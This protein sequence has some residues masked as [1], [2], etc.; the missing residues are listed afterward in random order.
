MF[1]VLIEGTAIKLVLFGLDGPSWPKAFL[2]AL[3]LNSVSGYVGIRAGISFDWW[4]FRFEPGVLSVFL[5][6]LGIE[7]GALAVLSF[8]RIPRAVAAAS[9][10]NL[11]SYAFLVMSQ[12]PRGALPALVD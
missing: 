10:M 2:L 9:V 11:A 3:V 12:F 4:E 5:V 8:R 1:I 7:G 6:S